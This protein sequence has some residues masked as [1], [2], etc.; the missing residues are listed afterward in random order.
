MAD[1]KEVS[2][3]N[4]K[5]SGDLPKITELLSYVFIDLLKLDFFDLNYL[6]CGLTLGIW[7]QVER[8]R[9]RLKRQVEKAAKE[10]E[11]VRM[12][13]KKPRA[14]EGKLPLQY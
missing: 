10:A 2:S 13:Q 7:L 14:K 3:F 11:K 9:I 8:N 5:P 1:K 4:F 6:S 12:Q